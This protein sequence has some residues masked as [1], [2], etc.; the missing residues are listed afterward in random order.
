M[1]HL[2]HDVINYYHINMTKTDYR[3]LVAEISFVIH[4]RTIIMLF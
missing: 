4:S 2:L 1:P 3:I